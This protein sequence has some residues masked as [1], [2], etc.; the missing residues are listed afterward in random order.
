MWGRL[1]ELASSVT[2]LQGQD[3]QQVGMARSE[4][5]IFFK[6]IES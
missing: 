5:I 4:L 2:G 3:A 6:V 1:T